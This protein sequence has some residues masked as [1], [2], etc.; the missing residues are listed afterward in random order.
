MTSITTVPET[1]VLS[2]PKIET[3]SLGQ[4]DSAHNN[5]QADVT[6][7]LPITKAQTDALQQEIKDYE[8]SQ[9]FNAKV[10]EV[11]GVKKV[12]AHHKAIN[13]YLSEKVMQPG[14]SVLELGCAA[15]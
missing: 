11:K 14:W 6:K 7:C 1:A 2:A 12:A 10:R 15:A 13:K 3:L 9:R 4:V 8:G 5:V